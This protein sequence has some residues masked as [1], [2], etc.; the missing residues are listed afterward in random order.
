MAQLEGKIALVTGGSRGVGKGVV[1][2]LAEA[3]AT[4]Y[5][6]ARTARQTTPVPPQVIP[7]RCDHRKDEDVEAAFRH[8]LATQ[9][10]L[11]ILVN[12]VWGGYERM[13]EGG[14]FTWPYPF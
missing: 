7:L 12:N 14:E 11:D 2:G 9:P 8:L 5:F 4:A 6:T 10:R 1:Q 13:V 3:G